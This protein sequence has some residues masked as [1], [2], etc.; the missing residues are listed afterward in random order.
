[1]SVL[2]RLVLSLGLAFGLGCA[3]AVRTPLYAR[4][5]QALPELSGKTVAVL[6][7]I[8]F[9]SEV[10]PGSRTRQAAQ[11]IFS[12]PIR[13]TQFVTPDVCTDRLRTVPERLEALRDAVIANLP[14]DFEPAGEA[15]EIFNGLSVGGVAR[16]RPRVITLKRAAGVRTLGPLRVDPE[17]LEPLESDYVL[18]PVVYGSYTK[19][20]NLLTFYGF[21]PYLYLSNVTA[22][23]A[24]LLALLYD[25]AT[26]QKQ[27]EAQ[28]GVDGF[29]FGEAAENPWSAPLLGVAYLLTGDVETALARLAPVAAPVPDVASD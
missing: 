1:M 18:I 11:E 13:D 2:P 24:K 16:D 12:Q 5:L 21:I 4:T 28:I 7:P 10:A 25:G 20:A 23:P 19:S 27:W 14:A 3:G 26:G 8:T 17:W 29:L 15:T 9:G 6:P 22:Q